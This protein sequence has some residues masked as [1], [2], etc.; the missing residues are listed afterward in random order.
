MK[1]TPQFQHDC[2]ACIFLG[3]MLA[4]GKSVDLY[5]C[6]NDIVRSTV[7]ARYSS[8]GSDYASGMVFA[9][10]RAMAELVV[11]RMLAIEKGLIKG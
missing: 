4:G 6:P 7:V 8:E 11:A 2:T 9:E 10:N 3:N 1:D 5:Y